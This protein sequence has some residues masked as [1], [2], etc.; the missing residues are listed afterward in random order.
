MG[1]KEKV[2]RF[3]GVYGGSGFNGGGAAHKKGKRREVLKY[4]LSAKD[5][6][7]V[8]LLNLQNPLNL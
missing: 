4:T 2:D 1:K 7:P 8:N 3:Y 6:K 5:E